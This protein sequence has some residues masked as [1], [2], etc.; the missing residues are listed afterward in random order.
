MTVEVTRA[1]GKLFMPVVKHDAQGYGSAIT[2][3]RRYSLLTACGV[4]PEDD[5][6]NTAAAA[7]PAK[8]IHTPTGT[9]IVAPE[10]MS[11]I[12]DV[13]DAQAGPDRLGERDRVEETAA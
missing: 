3:G 8:I 13:A 5:D 6:G 7:A 11:I 4:A 1:G 12:A 10:R 9:P 2:Y